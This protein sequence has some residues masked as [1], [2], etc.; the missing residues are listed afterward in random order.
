MQNGVPL[1]NIYLALYNLLQ[2]VP[3]PAGVGGKPTANPAVFSW[4]WTSRK[5][6]D[7]DNIPSADMP[8]A[9]QHGG[10]IVSE[11]RSVFQLPTHVLRAYWWIFFRA[12]SSMDPTVFPDDTVQDIYDAINNT[13]QG[14]AT[15]ER[16]TLAGTIY[17]AWTEGCMYEAAIEDNQ[18]LMFVP[19][20]MR[21]GV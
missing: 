19:I 2:Q 5:T 7:W 11:Q 9:L 1:K 8:F 21:T 10:P 15:G 12:D 4:Q 3:L 18:V 13:L 6:I 16:Q 14:P 17:H 20:I